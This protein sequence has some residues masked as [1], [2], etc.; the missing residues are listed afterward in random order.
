MSGEVL[1]RRFGGSAVRHEGQYHCLASTDG[2]L[3]KNITSWFYLPR[4][5][6]LCLDHIHPHVAALARP[7]QGGEHD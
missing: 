2:E 7:P 5:S 4:N 1:E 6:H 3:C